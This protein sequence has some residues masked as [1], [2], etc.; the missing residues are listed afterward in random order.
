MNS[1]QISYGIIRAVLI[2][3]LIVLLGYVI[4]QIRVIFLYILF[5][6][7]ISLLGRPL[8][9]FLRNKLKFPRDL[10]VLFVLSIIF[11]LLIGL[12]Y[13]LTPLI[14]EQ[15]KQLTEIDVETYKYNLQNFVLEIGEFFGVSKLEM[16]NY[17][18]ESEYV[19]EF[20]M[21]VIYKFIRNVF[22]SIG[23]L[24]IGF[25]SVLFISFFL[26]RD[27]SILINSILVFVNKGEEVKVRLVFDRIKNL[28]SRYF[29]GV[30]TQ[31]GIIFSL[32]SILLL[33]IGVDNA[34][35]IALICAILNI[36]P[37][38]GP[39][40]G[41]S[42]MVLFV[43]SNNLGLNFSII[44]FPQ[45]VSITLGFL[46]IQLIDNLLNQPIIFGKSVKAHPLEIFVVI[47]A[48]GF[49]FG[50]LGMIIAVP[51]YTAI[52]VIASQFWSDYKIVDRLTRNFKS[53]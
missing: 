31:L 43:I 50:V 19:K 8:V 35:T 22:G 16:Y 10:A 7:V 2:L 20:D 21:N 5:S 49:L 45:L 28:L 34:V 44:V 12:F 33:F 13:I 39:I 1:K 11:G 24:L 47:I 40:M 23:N 46:I 9:I 51:T 17:I 36:I 37:Y 29:L 42:L 6:S 14:V 4:F 3:G 41:Y 18:S 32:N 38:L 15:G 30:F 27:S 53:N 48:S 26:L 25:F 52:K